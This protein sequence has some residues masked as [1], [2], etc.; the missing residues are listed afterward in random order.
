MSVE[1]GKSGQQFIPSSI[2]KI[3]WLVEF[4]EQNNLK[5]LIEVDGGI[6]IDNIK[7]VKDAGVDVVV[8]G[9]AIY[10]ATNKKEYIQSLRDA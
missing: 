6:N 9:S 8:S 1:P 3:K 5:F 10:N 7:L 4:R 2:D